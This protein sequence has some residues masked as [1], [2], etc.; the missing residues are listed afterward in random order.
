MHWKQ[1][2]YFA[3]EKLFY[4]AGV[5][6]V[7]TQAHLLPFVSFCLLPFSFDHRPQNALGLLHHT[8]HTAMCPYPCQ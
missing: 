6:S 8:H 7:V 5:L 1:E 2:Q 4:G 3:V